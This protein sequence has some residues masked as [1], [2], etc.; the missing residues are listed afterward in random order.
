M[1]FGAAVLPSGG[2]RFRL[3]APGAQKVDV[4]IAEKYFPMK[5]AGDG[6]YE[7]V[8]ADAAPGTLY[9]YRIDGKQLVPDPASRF[10]PR[11]VDGPSEVIALRSTRG[12]T[13]GGAAGRGTRRWST[14]CT[15]ARSRRRAPTPEWRAR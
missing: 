5:A 14:S 6:W 15:S 8:H 7:L 10:Q 9:K 11:D 1:P 3:W 4:C 13:P 2:I 12:R